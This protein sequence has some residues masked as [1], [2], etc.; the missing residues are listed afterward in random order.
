MPV[1]DKKKVAFDDDEDDED[2]GFKKPPAKPQPGIKKAT[3]NFLDDDEDDDDFKMPGQAKPAPAKRPPSISMKKDLPLGRKKS[4][5][6]DDEDDEDDFA[7]KKPAAAKPPPL[8][9]LGVPPAAKPEPPK[10]PDPPKPKEE[11]PPAKP[12]LPKLPEPVKA[13]APVVAKPP[14]VIE[15][16]PRDSGVNRKSSVITNERTLSVAEIIEK[17]NLEALIGRGRPS[18][19]KK[20]PEPIRESVK[21]VDEDLEEFL[22]KNKEPPMAVDRTISVTRDLN[23]DDMAGKPDMYRPPAKAKK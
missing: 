11:A 10:Q 7:F 17:T 15:E 8:P 18:M 22:R 2:L 5:L 6:L 19:K 16:A 13:P 4:V 9:S 3:P 1:V 23:V 12:Q 20:E 21:E 14:P